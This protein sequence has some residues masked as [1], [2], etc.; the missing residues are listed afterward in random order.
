[1]LCAKFDAKCILAMTATATSKTLR[2]VMH[3]LEIPARNL[4]QAAKM[5]ENLQLSVSM[6]G[7]R[8]V[9]MRFLSTLT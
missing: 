1:M 6:T 9:Y 3:A 2:D 7:S 8:Q 5:R 4:I